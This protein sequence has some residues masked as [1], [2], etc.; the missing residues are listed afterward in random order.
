MLTPIVEKD[1]VRVSSNWLR[2]EDAFRNRVIVFDDHLL[3]TTPS[4]VQICERI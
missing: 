1:S 2:L 4:I 3:I